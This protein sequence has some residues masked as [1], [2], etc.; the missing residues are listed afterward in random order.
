MLCKTCNNPPRAQKLAQ[1]HGNIRA[2]SGSSSSILE[3]QIAPIALLLVSVT[4]PTT[5][6]GSVQRSRIS[7]YNTSVQNLREK[8]LSPF[9]FYSRSH[10][11]ISLS[12]SLGFVPSNSIS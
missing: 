10:S 9:P 2:A 8:S 1:E 3:F 6:T 5:P 7:K 11:I 12:P 4:R